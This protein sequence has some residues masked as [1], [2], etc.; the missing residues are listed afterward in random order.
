M[1]PFIFI[2]FF[3]GV[4]LTY[5]QKY[6][7]GK[8]TIDELNEKRH[9]SDSSANACILFKTGKVEYNYTYD[10]GFEITTTFKIKIKIYKK[11]GYDWAN[12]SKRYYIAG[13]SNE[14]VSFSDAST[15]N[16]VDGKI[17]KTK[18]KSNGEFDE[19]VNKYWARKKI[20]M[21][22][23]KEGSIVEFECITRSFRLDDIEN[24]D[25]QESIPVKYSELKTY[26]PEYF[27]YNIQ[28]KGFVFPVVKKEK[29]PRTLNYTIV[30][31]FEP[32][33]NTVNTNTNRT[34]ST[35]DFIEDVSTYTITDVPALK[36]EAFV[37]NINNYKSSLSHELSVIEIP[38]QTI[39]TFSTDW[40]T[41][42]DFIY[43]S[44][45]FGAELN[46]SGYFEDDINTLI[47]G[48][49]NENE[50]IA[51]IYNFVKSK[52]KWNEYNGYYCDG[53]VKKAYKEQVGNAAE[54]N[55]ML[56]AMLRFARIEAN[57]VLISTRANE[58]ASYPNRNAFNFVIAGIEKENTIIL[59]DATDKNALPNILPIKNLNWIGRI[60]RKNGSST[61]V[62]LMPQSISNDNITMMATISADGVVQGK[63]R[64]QYFD[65]NGYVYRNRFG[66]SNEESYLEY[67]EKKMNDSEIEEFEVTGKKELNEPIV[68]N[69]MFKNNNSVEIIGDKMFFSPMLFLASDENPFK[70]EEREYPI[71]FIYPNQDRYLISITIPDGYQVESLPK[72]ISIPMSDNL[73]N[74]KYL[75]SNSGNKI[76]LSY[77]VDTNTSIISSEY[78]GE[79][80]AVYSEIIKKENE[81]IILK[82][83]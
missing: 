13:K 46:K 9:P 67:L 37:N 26:I 77:T 56:V 70:Q 63:M 24:W 38:G 68:E 54:I 61:E 74:A 79:L 39:Q 82:K 53:G 81:K 27:H 11:E 66:D 50:K 51:A 75:V 17:E 36:E 32:G 15:Y 58:I 71:D 34:N 59:L 21:P 28:Q 73:I 25:F 44:D 8:V 6:N 23:V 49:T 14:V 41:V 80:K 2:L 1:K 52:V 64:E 76:Q 22:N 5:S 57:P 55:L 30:K 72:S 20:T 16:L 42:T 19:K 12:F 35:L 31:N 48:I 83:I 7:L 78:Y 43:K 33:A 69:Y 60:I 18:L 47:S 40:E 65:Y 4:T 62:D 45:D 3:F 29:K 10:K